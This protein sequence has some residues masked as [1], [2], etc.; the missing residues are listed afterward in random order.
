MSDHESAELR[1]M[2]QEALR[3][4]DQSQQQMQAYAEQ[5][6]TQRLELM[7]IEQKLAQAELARDAARA[8]RSK[9]EEENRGLQ[10]QQ[11]L[12]QRKLQDEQQQRGQNSHTDTEENQRLRQENMA[13]VSELAGL[14]HEYD[15]LKRLR[16]ED[17]ERYHQLEEQYRQMDVDAS[18]W[19]RQ[20]EEM[21]ETLR[22]ERSK[23][24]TRDNPLQ[25][26]VYELEQLLTQTQAQREASQRMI[27][28][29][30][31]DSRTQAAQHTQ[32][33][34]QAQQETE[35]LRR[36]YLE[37]EKKRRVAEAQT[38]ALSALQEQLKQAEQQL[39][40]TRRARDASLAIRTQLQEQ[41][42]QLKQ[43]QTQPTDEDHLREELEARIQAEYA[44]RLREGETQ[45]QALKQALDAQINR[46]ALLEGE[47]QALKQQRIVAAPDTG[48]LKTQLSQLEQELA[49]VRQSRVTLEQQLQQAQ[50]TSQNA[51]ANLETVQDNLRTAELRAR[52]QQD[53]LTIT[54]QQ[55]V[56]ELEIELQTSKQQLA[57]EQRHW[58][59]QLEAR[60]SQ[61]NN[62][63]QEIAT[64][65]DSMVSQDEVN[66]LKAELRDTRDRVEDARAGQAAAERELKRA[67]TEIVSLTNNQ[68]HVP[69][70][71][72]SDNHSGG[73]GW[74]LGGI[75]GLGLTLGAL[76]AITL[77]SGR[78]EL[79]THLLQSQPIDTPPTLAPITP[80]E[81]TTTALD[82]TA[83]P[84][85]AKTKPTKITPKQREFRDK[86]K[87]G[88][89]G[90]VMLEL[91]GGTV[92]LGSNLQL[93]TDEQPKYKTTL[94]PFALGKYEIT[95]AEY[96]LY[97]T[98]VGKT[99]APSGNNDPLPATNLSWQDAQDYATWLSAQTGQRYRLPREA[100]WEYAVAGG[101]GNLY[102]WGRSAKVGM[103]NC[104]NC[105][106]NL[107][108]TPLPIGQFAA[109]PYGLH[110]L[111]GNV[112]EW[113]QDC[114]T[115]SYKNRDQPQAADCGLRSI[116]G[117]GYD[118]PMDSLR[119][120]KRD[121]AAPSTA[122][123]NLGFRVARDL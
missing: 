9:L 19:R 56:S 100:E 65:R 60:A 29:R 31:E 77:L 12:L 33:L 6:R 50:Q 37:A 114:Y 17:T 116:R 51:K 38:E 42:V 75:L 93:G 119:T 123:D 107:G 84:K 34:R 111:T 49:Q 78:G 4:R 96:R 48:T 52:Q 115:N 2:Y 71:R 85:T 122:L 59:T 120:T 69:A 15:E 58:Q 43:A 86:L 27:L 11:A 106:P 92:E 26:R 40:Q 113:V 76:E 108:R 82:D 109:N 73:L 74:V 57:Q 20:V 54:A 28:Q 87:Q 1:R 23:N 104:F 55:A 97:I 102:W 21:H 66:R 18:V 88:S 14:K 89:N 95:Q 24:Q 10:V 121:K 3:A 39:E 7:R 94:A 68:T 110:D 8:G 99:W 105:G 64:L 46:N 112:R 41:L 44:G 61:V 80:I 101:S 5:I 117:G 118:S 35:T 45:L 16:T 90:P 103:A 62:L 98:A 30:E 91:A 22:Q 13:L 36:R 67:Q 47:Y 83:P 72:S 53:Q 81:P 70:E 63:R 79:L 32:A 25:A